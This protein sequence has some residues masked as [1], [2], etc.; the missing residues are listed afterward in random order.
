MDLVSRLG[1]FSALASL[2]VCATSAGQETLS[3]AEELSKK[4]EAARALAPLGS[5]LFGDETNWYNGQ[6]TFRVVDVDIPGNSALPVQIT[7]TLSAAP[8]EGLP[9][10]GLP[11][12]M[13]NWE[14]E[15]PYVSSMV[16]RGAGWQPSARCTSVVGQPDVAADGVTFLADEYWRGYTISI[17]GHDSG[18]MLKRDPA[19]TLTPTDAS[20]PWVTTGHTQIKCTD[21][22]GNQVNLQNGTG[23]GFF[24]VT[25]DGTRYRFDWQ[26]TRPFTSMIKD[27]NGTLDGYNGKLYRDEVRIYAT[28]VEDRFGNW[29]S[30]TYSGERLD[31]VESND[32]RVITLA[33]NASN[34][35]ETVTA[36]ASSPPGNRNWTYS[37]GVAGLTAV[38]LPDDTSWTME[39]SPG[40]QI[41]YGDSPPA[42]SPCHLPPTSALSTTMSGPRTWR[43]THPNGATGEFT[44]TV[45]RHMRTE[46]PMDKHCHYI[47]AENE[48]IPGNVNEFDT[49]ALTSKTLSGPGLTPKTWTASYGGG[50]VTQTNPDSTKARYTF[51]T[52]WYKDE[53]KLVRSEILTAAGAV[54]RDTQTEYAINPTGQAYAYRI[55][56]TM[57]DVEDAFASVLVTTTL[58][59]TTT[60]DSATFKSSTLLGDFDEYARP[61]VIKEEKDAGAQFTK[62]ENVV[63]H[64]KTAIWVLGQVASVTDQASGMIA[65]RTV[66][67]P[68]T[69]LPVERYSFGKLMQTLEYNADG[70]PASVADGAGN[71]TLLSNWKRGLPQAIQ[72]PATDEC[73][74]CGVTA[75]VHDAGWILSVTD[76]RLNT[77]SYEYDFAGRIKRIIYPTGDSVAWADTI[78]TYQVA[79]AGELG[80]DTGT[81]RREETTANFRKRTYF[82][83]RLRPVL[84]EQFDSATG[85]AIYARKSFDFDGREIFTS[86]PSSSSTASAGINTTFDALGRATQR[87]TTA[88][89]TLETIAY[90]S[91]GRRKVTDARG[92]VTTTSFQAFDEPSYEDAVLI[93]APEGQTTVIDRDVFGAMTSATQSGLY[94]GEP[95]SVTRSYLYDDGHR[96][97]KRIEPE[98]GQKVMDYDLAGNIAWTADG[99][100]GPTNSCESSVTADA[101]TIFSYNARN[102][103]TEVNA[104]GAD[105]DVTTTYWP[106]GD[107]QAIAKED[108]SA[109]WNYAFNKRRLLESEELVADAQ[110]FALGYRFNTQGVMD[111]ITYPSHRA[112]ALSPDAFG[113]SR[114]VGGYA[115]N[116]AYHP[117]GLVSAFNYVGTPLSYSLTLDARQRPEH[118]LLTAGGTNRLDLQHQYDDAGNL[119]QIVDAGGITAGA[120]SRTMTYDGLNRLASASGLWGNYTFYYDPLN[121]LRHRTGGA[122][123]VNFT[124]DSSNRMSS[125]AGALSRSYSYNDEGQVTGDGSKTFV[126]NGA[127]RITSIPGVAEYVYD[128]LGKRFK[129]VK[130]DGSIEYAVYNRAGHLVHTHKITAEG[131][132]AMMAGS[133]SGGSGVPLPIPSVNT[134]KLTAFLRPAAV[135]SLSP[136]DLAAPGPTLGSPVTFS[137]DSSL[138]ATSYELWV[139]DEGGAIVS[140]ASTEATTLGVDLPP[141]GKYAW[142]IDA[143]NPFGCVRSETL[144]FQTV[145]A[146]PAAPGSAS[147]GTASPPGPT[148]AD[149]VVGLSWSASAS[150]SSYLV[151]VINTATGAYVVNGASTSATTYSASLDYGTGYRWY[152]SACNSGGCHAT[153]SL[154]FRTPDSP[155]GSAPATPAN[156][157]PGS[158]SAPGPTTAS[159]SVTLTWSASSGA[160]SYTVSVVNA[161]TGATAVNAATAATSY[162]ATLGFAT[163]WRWTVNACNAAG[164][165]EATANRYF[166]TPVQPPPATPANPAPGSTS[167]PGPTTPDRTVTLT[168]SAASGATSY[169]VSVIDVATGASVSNVS[170]GA[171]S[172]EATFSYG[173]GYRWSVSACNGGG[174][175]AATAS[176]YFQTPAQ[177]STRTDYIFLSGA[178]IAEVKQINAESATTSYVHAD[179]LGSPSQSSDAAG[180][181]QWSEQYE[182][183]GE[184]MN[185]GEYKLGYTGH[186]HDFES[187]LTYM[188]AR[189]YDAQVSRFLSVDPV[190]FDGTN[191]FAFN[192]YAYANNNPY[193][194]SDPTGTCVQDACVIETVALTNAIIATGVII[195]AAPLT[196]RLADAIGD[197]LSGAMNSGEQEPSG[198]Q[199]APPDV[200]SGLVGEQDGK[201]GA[202]GSRHNSGP[203]SPKNGGTG[204]AGKDFEK[205]TGGKS[206]P[207]PEDKDYPPGTQIG[208]NG[209]TLRPGTNTNGP[210]IDVPAKG[211]KPAETLHYP[212]SEQPKPE[213]RK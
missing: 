1:A 69:A 27:G 201:G 95:V 130:A 79:P 131:G 53:G 68:D 23:Q 195:A 198:T 48:L 156:P 38:A 43:F 54:L 122:G 140:S 50:V 180:A 163:A 173:T 153:S 117:N 189:Y 151:Y 165:S 18:M 70:T 29:V 39:E 11:R 200:P 91:G 65:K 152:V 55:G 2:F 34:N 32:G 77:T 138:L 92:K 97:C 110:T 86:Y 210:R 207:A 107:P 85:Q 186:A 171:T 78:I 149:R 183:Y 135:T 158:T 204:D 209:I 134:D 164:C 187:G 172:Y 169:T 75:D 159:N 115:T 45:V 179:L 113:R 148:T 102:L 154:Y 145:P 125:V 137:W 146:A 14:L 21:A 83:A 105:A 13:G 103:V 16:S 100:S 93:E 126:W 59:T 8:V 40:L 7:R 67:H 56:S 127:D 142:V 58:S 108:G 89:T 87:Q 20:Y 82:D 123:A 174:C 112:V 192:R 51:G 196:I 106:T 74:P 31:R 205:L 116:V 6:T 185:G 15:L 132:S 96:L 98:T 28:R 90:L 25:A 213:D 199:G 150:A 155:G 188:Q 5:G 190:E 71:K 194:Y 147:P 49:Y 41:V 52:R 61:R 144:Y 175:S 143:C 141:G 203:L 36:Q 162:S 26:T 12:L 182:P 129:T 80:V 177:P 111:Q 120:D 19:Y 22:A 119:T 88:G 208:T 191:P 64:D 167:A 118:M 161:S 57:Q 121:N 4:I 168:W 62:T 109:T 24:A 202:S 114:A 193:K 47:A 178:V 72:H 30:Y 63:Y 166:Q 139:L 76:E 33:Y 99:Q 157:S 3:Y 128:G 46:I 133:S 160:T 35:V 181:L 206:G 42:S 37:Y 66:Y 44:F 211:D 17:P 197:A 9:E 104:P 184:K 60:Q 170:V 101:K 124:H 212:K 73:N 94:A 84:E 176:R 10:P 136:G 81:W